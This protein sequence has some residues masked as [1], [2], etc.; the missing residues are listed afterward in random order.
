MVPSLVAF[1]CD[2]GIGPRWRM[3]AQLICF[4]KIELH[5]LIGTVRIGRMRVS[6][7]PELDNGVGLARRLS[8]LRVDEFST[9]IDMNS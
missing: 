6:R 5:S 7:R 9:D 8:R 3:V 2:N 4:V 1:R